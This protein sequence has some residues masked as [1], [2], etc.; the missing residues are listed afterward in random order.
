MHC[1]NRDP[2]TLRSGIPTRLIAA[3]SALLMLAACGNGGVPTAEEN[4]EQLTR[5]YDGPD[6]SLQFWNGFTGGD[7]PFMRELVTQFNDEHDKIEVSME[8]QEWGDFYETVPAAVG[9]GEGPHIGIMH[10]DQLATNA[11]RNVVQP[12]DDVAEILELD[13]GDFSEP[14]WNAGLYDDQRYGIPLD[15]HPLGFYYNKRLMEEAGLDPDEP[16]ND[17]DSYMEAL[18]A[19]R[20]ADIKGSWVS[21][22]QFTG[23]L[24]YQSLLWQFGGQLYTDDVQEAAWNS[25]EG[26]EALEWM[27]GLVDEGHSPSD[28]GQ[29]ADHIA[30]MNDDNAF[31]WNGIWA[32]QAYAEDEDLDWGVA[33]LPMIGDQNGVWGGSHNFV[34]MERRDADAD[35]RQASVVFIDWILDRSDEWA[36]AGQVPAANTARETETF[37]ALEHQPMFAE[38][39]P[40]TQFPP[41]VP[42]I[43][44]AQGFLATAVNE[45]VLGEK[46]PQQALDDAANAANEILAENRA[47]FS[48]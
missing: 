8:V 45:A 35:E 25:S 4:G 40:D 37:N 11:V 16:P 26:V 34:L 41:A 30:F 18:D 12:L 13:E 32:I 46:T 10:V 20:D 27:V 6:V 9:T 47:R 42:G 5:G 24:M 22:H 39:L 48:E 31:I 15:V 36:E 43:G 2:R 23:G 1:R 33:P 3:L 21:P 14:V 38:Q 28:V 19:L 29:D 17:R 44:D 7:G